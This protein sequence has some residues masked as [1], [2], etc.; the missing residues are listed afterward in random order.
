MHSVS[1]SKIQFLN[2]KVRR[3]EL[4][5]EEHK[6]LEESKKL[7]KDAGKKKGQEQELTAEELH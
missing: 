3:R 5:E 6:A 7:K 1:I 4:T 2:G